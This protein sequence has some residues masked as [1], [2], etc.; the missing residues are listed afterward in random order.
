M[1]RHHPCLSLSVYLLLSHVT[2][3]PRP[4]PSVLHNQKLQVRTRLGHPFFFCNDLDVSSSPSDPTQLTVQEFKFTSVNLPA[5]SGNS[6][7]QLLSFTSQQ[8]NQFS[9]STMDQK[10]LQQ[11]LDINHGK[12]ELDNDK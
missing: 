9:L 3:S 10:Y 1:I 4:C 8:F 5:L 2:R 7:H 11:F 12:Q 6:G